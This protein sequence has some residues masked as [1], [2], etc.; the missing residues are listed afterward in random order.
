MGLVVLICSIKH[1]I[2]D[3]NHGQ[4]PIQWFEHAQNSIYKNDI[5]FQR[6]YSIGYSAKVSFFFNA[7]SC[8]ISKFMQSTKCSLSLLGNLMK[9]P[10][11][12]AKTQ[13]SHRK[14]HTK[15]FYENYQ[16]K[17]AWELNSAWLDDHL[18]IHWP[19]PWN[20]LRQHC[21]ALC[22]Q[23]WWCIDIQ[24]VHSVQKAEVTAGTR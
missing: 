12:Q 2:S 20:D 13:G 14:G 15:N 21:Q 10:I 11:L 17:E 7:M 6:E 5:Y 9:A 3:K 22:F 4:L 16:R 18:C 8:L 24:S 23:V 1:C 19:A